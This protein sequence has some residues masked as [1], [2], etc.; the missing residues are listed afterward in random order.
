MWN[1]RNVATEGTDQPNH[2]ST[3]QMITTQMKQEDGVVQMSGMTFIVIGG[4]CNLISF[5]SIS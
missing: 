1:E 3:G 2:C 5:N 4:E